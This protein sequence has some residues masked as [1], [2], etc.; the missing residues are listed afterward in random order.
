[1]LA[2][3]DE[4]VAALKVVEAR[5]GIAAA[6]IDCREGRGEWALGERVVVRATGDEDQAV[7]LKVVVELA[8]AD[9]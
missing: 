5:R 2:F 6:D 7:A 3:R 8:P 1:M 9:D 4:V